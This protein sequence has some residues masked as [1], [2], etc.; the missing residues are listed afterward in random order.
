MGKISDKT[1]KGHH[2][3]SKWQSGWTKYRMKESRK[4]PSFVFCTVC[5][6]DVSVAGGGVHEIKRHLETNKHVKGLKDVAAQPAIAQ[7]M[8][9]G[10]QHTKLSEKTIQSEVYFTKFVAEHN[11]SFRTAEH[12]SKLVKVM[13]PDSKV[14]SAFSCSRTKTAAIVN[15]AL[16][17]KLNEAVFAACRSSPFTIMCDGGNDDMDRK[18]FGLMVRYWDDAFEQAVTRFLAMP[19][20]NIATG[21]TLFNAI[22][23]ELRTHDIPWGN[24]VG[25][26]SDSASVMVGKRN[27]VLSRVKEVSP[28]VFSLGCVCHLANL[29]AAAA[30][31]SLPISVD[32]LLIDIF[33]YFKHSA[34]RWEMFA[35]IQREFGDVQPAR[36]LKHST[37]R[38]MSIKRCLKRFLDQWDALYA[39]F[40]RQRDI[41]PRNDRVKRVVKLLEAPLT[42]LVCQ[43]VLFAL[44]PLNKFTVLFQTNASRVGTMQADF[45]NLL[46]S[47][48]ANF[49]DASAIRNCTNDELP[50]LAYNDRANQLADSELGIG[51][52]ARLALLEAEDSSDVNME[53]R[54]HDS[55]RSFYEACVKK[56]LA[57]FP[58]TDATI[59]NLAFL[60]PKSRSSV[61]ASAIL[62]ICRKLL[63]SASA[64]DID[65]VM[66]EFLDF[67]TMPEEQLPAVTDHAFLDQFWAQLSK[68]PSLHDESQLRFPNLGKLAKVAL[69]LPHSNA[70]P[71]RLF[72]MVKKIE[73]SQRGHLKPETTCN[74]I[75][76]KYNHPTPCFESTDLMTTDFLTAAKRATMESLRPAAALTEE[77]AVE[78]ADE[79][80]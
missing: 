74:L 3:P 77:A 1:K 71:E 15:N 57:K 54:F 11:L 24:V 47:Y 43:F 27:S 64:E 45:L 48:L 42:K 18:Y 67:K 76:C 16:A 49:M 20:C 4:G 36:V 56:L 14:A 6:V 37:T 35:E 55:V 65:L 9:V 39:F 46:R 68:L 25:F 75:S 62:Q 7:A 32:D 5:Q 50:S 17:P 60:N 40:D 8:A 79:L 21:E 63:T 34:K 23:A 51:T 80:L 10:Q 44:E 66:E 58:L 41:E 72:S 78:D 69:V 28:N 59:R 33:Y 22:D 31:K 53:A 61:T 13:F 70:D 12:F 73:T 29:C 2:V 38:W 19:I 30:L 26:C 52:Q